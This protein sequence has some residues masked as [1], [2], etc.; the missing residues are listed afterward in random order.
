MRR[1]SPRSITTAIA[2]AVCFLISTF[3]VNHF[4]RQSEEVDPALK[5][6][7]PTIAPE[8]ITSRIEVTVIQRVEV[9]VPSNGS[10]YFVTKTL[11]PLPPCTP[12][13]AEAPVQR[14]I[15]IYYPHHQGEYF[16]PEVRW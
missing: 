7:C 14:A 16:F 13:T 10:S 3:I 1:I 5:C 2:I 4:N 12:I 11:P 6:D 9:P 15:I 8:I